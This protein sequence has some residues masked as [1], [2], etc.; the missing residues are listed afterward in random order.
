MGLDCKGHLTRVV[1]LIN[2]GGFT[3]CYT[4]EILKKMRRGYDNYSEVLL[5][6]LCFEVFCIVRNKKLRFCF[7][8][9][10]NYMS[11]IYI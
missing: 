6:F 3:L 7:L 8:C 4:P 9:S 5:D 10:S 2:S 11:I 1:F